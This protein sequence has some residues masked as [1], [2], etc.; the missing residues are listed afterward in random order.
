MIPTIKDARAL[1]HQYFLY[2]REIGISSPLGADPS[3]SRVASNS[4][5]RS[6][7]LMCDVGVCLEKLPTK[8]RMLIM[9]RWELWFKREDVDVIR[10]K[11]ER[12][13]LAAMKAQRKGL[14]RQARRQAKTAREEGNRLT[15]K[16]A[17]VERDQVYI[18]GLKRFW[19][20]ATARD[21][22][23]RAICGERGRMSGL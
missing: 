9:Y 10:S 6:V 17:S 20:E 22:Y 12:R 14:H 19:V 15:S 11:W 2:R 1:L 23:A 16:I 7:G 4:F 13:A 8:Q 5:S 3:A 18:D 21:L